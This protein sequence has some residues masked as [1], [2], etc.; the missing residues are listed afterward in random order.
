MHA[1]QLLARLPALI[2]TS[3]ASAPGDKLACPFTL[4]P[5][6]AISPLSLRGA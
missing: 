5:R 2:Y 1:A 3:G 4:A 6:A